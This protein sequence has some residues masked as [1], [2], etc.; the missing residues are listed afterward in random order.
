MSART[1]LRVATNPWNDWYHVTVHA[2]GSW[3]R[4]DPRG[5]RSRHHREHV[6]GDYRHP[7]P[8][9]KY[10]RL[11]E[12]SKSLMK[13]NP[14]RM[15]SELR[16]FVANSVAEKLRQDGIQALIVSVDATHVHVLARF[17]DHNPRHWIGRAK[18]HA[19][20]LVRQHGLRIDAGGLWAKRCHCDPIADRQHQLNTFRYILDHARRGARV[21]RFD[22]AT[23]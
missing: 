5:W 3:L 1:H 15:M 12:L 17:P 6:D 11:Y 7:P 19:S 21:W 13:R 16:T 10:D 20:H 2:Y 9:G 4:G 23:S 18:K 8:K 14:V 22:R